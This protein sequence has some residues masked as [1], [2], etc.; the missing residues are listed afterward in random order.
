MRWC[1]LF[2]L[3]GI[4]RMV[5]CDEVYVEVSVLVPGEYNET[6]LYNNLLHPNASRLNVS[7]STGNLTYLNITNHSSVLILIPIIPFIPGPLI[8]F[9]SISPILCVIGFDYKCFND[10]NVTRIAD[11]AVDETPPNQPV[12]LIIGTSA[13]VLVV[14]A[15]SIVFWNGFRRRSVLV[16]PEKRPI[17]AVVI[18]WPPRNKNLHPGNG[19]YPTRAHPGFRL[20]N[21]GPSNA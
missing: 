13:A 1:V 10:T 9:L 4:I 2:V 11:D 12:G 8:R 18:D 5:R 7:D 14:V 3:V 6:N 19:Y 20:S 17:T 15:L 21:P 16:I